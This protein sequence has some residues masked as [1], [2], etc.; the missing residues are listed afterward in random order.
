[1]YAALTPD[2]PHLF[3]GVLVGGA[4]LVSLVMVRQVLAILENRR[5]YHLLHTAHQE[6]QINHIALSDAN[7]QLRALATT[8]AL[9]GLPN[10]RAMM[11]ALNQEL[12]RASRF[13]YSFAVLFLDLDHF[14]ALN[15]T[16]GHAVGDA[17]L[18]EFASTVQSAL[19]GVDILGRWGGEEF[20][21]ILPQTDA[22]QGLAVA[23]RVRAG[24]ADRVFERGGGAHMTCSIGVAVY[25]EDGG[26]R[27]TL[28]ERA[29]RAMYLAKHLGRNQVRDA[30]EATVAYLGEE[31]DGVDPRGDAALM[32]TVEALVRM[33]K[34]RDDC[35]DRHGQDVGTLTLQM[36]FAFG[37]DT[38]AARLVS[39][40]GRL[41][42]IGK[43][44]IPDR[45][46]RKP[47]RLTPSEWNLIHTHP[48]V[49]A[50][51]VS[52]VPGLR[53]L[54]PMIGGHHERW[55]GA[56]Y[57]DGRAGDQIPLGARIIAVADAF[58][59]MTS[60]RPYCVARSVG[61][62]LAEM[63][64]CAGTQFDPRVVEALERVQ[65]QVTAK[66]AG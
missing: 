46:L 50:D 32:G 8:D 58:Q 36:A 30:R 40:A 21:A 57:P 18:R 47:G 23:E 3:R 43:V 13:G 35:T 11:A 28:V 27:D 41:H 66:Q 29:D 26:E 19:R 45:I 38:H 20:V 15:D 12:E 59:A 61:D 2:D 33:V 51:V 65:Y 7:A 34:A 14:K 1:V 17:A 4:V 5:L 64:R 54:A 25:P 22:V 56:G 39:I 9:T 31:N 6:L 60:E 62:A 42:D 63:Q 44:A 49:G 53:S 48:M 10:H 24:V 16:H 37:M 55:D 52:Q